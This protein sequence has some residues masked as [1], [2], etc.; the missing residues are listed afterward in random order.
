[1]AKA[2]KRPKTTKR[3]ADPE[4]VRVGIVGCGAIS[5]NYMNHIPNYRILNVVACADLVPQRAKAMA[6]Q[7]GIPK[8]CSVK[9]LINDDDVDIVLNLTIPK[10]HYPVAMDAVRAGKHVYSEKPLAIRRPDGR[11]LVDAA[12]RK[13]LLVGGAPDTFFGAGIQTSRKLLDDGA[14]GQ[15]IAC[16]AYMMG[17]GVETWHPNPD[18][19][20]QP[21]GGPMFD[22][23]PYYLTA[24]TFLLGPIK[25]ITAA[26]G[27]T[28]PER[29]I[30]SKPFY[31][32]K[33]TVNTPDHIS[34]SLVFTSGVI[35]TMCTSFAT[36]AAETWPITIFGTDGTLKV[37][38]PNGFDGDVFLYTKSKD[39]WR[40][41]KHTHAT[42]HGRAVGL[43]DMAHAIRSG[44]P[45]RAGAQQTYAVLDAMQ[46]FLDAA[47]T[48]RAYT[49]RCRYERPAPLPTRLRKGWLDD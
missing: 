47:R 15:P 18:F 35:G 17:R 23:G 29:R 26:A 32:Q 36:W 5:G 28:I 34:G 2:T 43:A 20:F 19:Y 1:M 11:K 48:G 13:G 40:T 4:P 41:V 42:G 9:Q 30:T 25:R 16:T 33:I 22:M 31:G 27:I 44:R 49:P 12:K 46:G 6:D 21:G 14:I 8:V 7:A 38:D 39:K 10:A 37:P 24:M 3:H 45:A